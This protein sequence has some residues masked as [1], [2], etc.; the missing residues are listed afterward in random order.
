[1]YEVFLS[2]LS[3]LAGIGVFIAGMNL[4]GDG[5]EKSAGNRM[6]RIFKKVSNNP[7]INVG[8]GAVVTGIIQSSA[9]T[10]VMSI[11]F[12]NAGVM[13]L[14]QATYIIMGANIGTTVT[15]LI[16]SLS[17]LDIAAYISAFAFIGAMLMFIK[18]EG[19]KRIGQI[20]C[21]LG[22]VFIGLG[23]MSGAF[24]NDLM[25]DA[26][27]NIFL[28]IDFPLLLVVAGAVVTALIQS[29]STSTSLLIILVASGSMNLGTALYIVLGA[30]IGTCITAFI[31]SSGTSANAKRTAIIH[32][33]FN[34]LGGCIFFIVLCFLETQ[35]CALL[36][37]MIS[38][39]G[40]QLAWFHVI[41]NVTTTL[42]LLPFAKLLTKI[43]C[44]I[45]R[46]KKKAEEMLTN[47]F[48]DDRLI[49]TP[50]IAVQQTKREVEYM[51]SLAKANLALSF[52]SLIAKNLDKAEEIDKNEDILDFTN[53][54][55]THYLI[56]LGPVVSGND[57]TLIGSYFHVVNDIERIG[58]H[59]ENFLDINK[60]MNEEN[61]EFSEKAKQDLVMMYSK[62]E[63]M[64]EIAMNVFGKTDKDHLY[65]IAE[66]EDEVDNLKDQLSAGHVSRMAKGDCSVELGAYFYSLVSGLERVADHLVNVAYS[67]VNPIGT[68][69]KVEEK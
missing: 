63:K 34:L 68:V 62:I 65:Q 21:G 7:F 3:L 59:A 25:K 61:L 29:S 48:I 35:I 69:V 31:A 26:F 64:F 19:I 57:E 16:A 49:K 1:M 5:L 23:V 53:T 27:K 6:K 2:I 4:M 14:L 45:I 33:L 40:M 12:V 42:I 46:D 54:S 67:I 18:K 52:N 13:T 43:A 51:A 60:K 50:P 20:L 55:L 8:A 58:D 22:L 37:S 66:L 41:F 24:K 47:K 10:T 28:S 17:S 30:N 32:L 11:G 39:P 9:A 36:K 15:G 44:K 38:D 56:K